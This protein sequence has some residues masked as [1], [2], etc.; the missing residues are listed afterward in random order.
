MH[1]PVFFFNDTATTEISTLS[2]H[3]ALPIS[4][5]PLLLSPHAHSVPSDFS[6]T[7]WKKPAATAVQFVPVPI[8]TGLVRWVVVP[9]PSDPKSLHPHAQSLLSSFS[10]TVLMT[11]AAT[12][13]QFV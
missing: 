5:W 9:S 1:P 4:N 11:P 10:A 7:V 6:A 12:A 3:D 8:C 2:L 13:I